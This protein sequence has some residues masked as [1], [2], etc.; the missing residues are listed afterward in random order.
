MAASSKTEDYVFKAKLAEQA[1]RYADMVK[2]MT[3]IVRSDR[4]LTVEERN[5]LSVA[6]KNVVGSRRAAWRVISSLLTTEGR[7]PMEVSVL[8]E[9]KVKVETE[10]KQMCAEILR[11][12]RDTLIKESKETEEKVF[13][14]KMAGDY[15]RYLAEFA[16]Q[17][18][19]PSGDTVHPIEEAKTNYQAAMKTAE[20]GVSP[21]QMPLART[22]PILLGLTLNFSVFYYEILNKP[23]KACQ[24]AKTG[25]D[26]AVDELD[27]LEEDSY[28]DATLIM[29]LLRDN[30]TL[31]TSDENNLD[32]PGDDDEMIMEGM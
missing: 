6:Y 13:Y 24:L 32:P 9:Y 19:Q 20:D 26:K 11:L 27:E 21:S 2:F 1:E 17:V 18:T 30:L 10:L 31:W 16:N 4:N 29:Q 22:N 7:A 14:L 12:L 15:Y 23:E 28:K 25:F 8:K 3:K 5:M